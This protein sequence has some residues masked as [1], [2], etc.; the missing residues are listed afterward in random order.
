[1]CPPRRPPPPP[2]LPKPRPIAPKPEKTAQQVKVGAKRTS[3]EGGRRRRWS[4]RRTGTML[5]RIPLDTTSD[6][7]Y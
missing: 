4:R 3:T 2:P 1:M 5:L 6:L 7:R